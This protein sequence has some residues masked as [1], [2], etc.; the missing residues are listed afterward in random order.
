M[1][2]ASISQGRS[3]L[4]S[5]P[6]GSGKTLAAFLWAIDR[7]TFG[8]EPAPVVV[9]AARGKKR[10][11][12][13]AAMAPTSACR[14]LYVSPLKALAVDVERN[15]RA[16]IAGI[17]QTASAEGLR[18]RNVRVGVRTGDTSTKE[19]ELLKRSPPDILVTTPESLYL[20][21]T[22][23]AR[24][25]LATIDTVIVDEIHQLAGEKRGAHFFLSLERLEALR[26]ASRPDAPKLLRIGL[27]ATQK[28][29]EVTARLLAGH[30]ARGPREV[31]IAEAP[32]EKVFRVTVT[33]PEGAFDGQAAEGEERRPESSAWPKL[34][35]RLLEAI[36]AKRST[37]IFVNSRR[38]AERLAAALNDLAA[39]LAGENPETYPPLALAHHGSLARAAREEI[40]EKLKRGELRA[41]VATSSL[42]LGID[43]GAVDQVV[44]VESP[45]SIAAGIQRIGRAGHQVGAV[46]EGL[47]LPKHKADL[48]AATAAKRAIETGD[49]EP[50][51]VPKNPLDVLAQQVVA[52]VATGI[53]IEDAEEPPPIPADTVFALVRGTE[54]FATLPR[55]AFDGVL[56][57]LS[58]RYPSTDFS[59]LR[60]RLSWDRRTGLLT[61]RPFARRL[62]VLNAGTIPERG[63]Y[64]V[65]L[66]GSADP[67]KKRSLRVGELDEEM[68][69]ELREGDTFFLGASAWKVVDITRDQVIVNPA[70]GARGRPPFWHG[71]RLGR[72]KSFGARIGEL[73][74]AI[75]SREEAEARTYLEKDVGLDPSSAELLA[76]YVHE[77]MATLGDSPSDKTLVIERFQDEL[78]DHR[79][80]ILSPFGAR[81][82]APWAVAIRATLSGFRDGD[83]EAVYSDDGITLR[84]PE[85]DGPPPLEALALDP[86]TVNEIVTAE[87]GH[88]ALFAARFREAAGRA[89]LLPKRTPGKRTP[90]WALR[91]KSSDLLAVASRYPDFPLML[92]VHR[93]CL[94]DAFDMTGLTELLE[95]I[96]ARK[97]R[98]R[99]V[100][101]KTPSAFSKSLLFSFVANFLYDGDAPLAERR[102]QALLVDPEELRALLGEAELRKL[103]DPDIARALEDE[104]L[105]LKYPLTT[106]DGLHDLLLL[107]GDLSL[108]EVTARFE[109]PDGAGAAERAIA[110]LVEERRIAKVRIARETRLVA[111]EDAARYRDALGVVLPP[112][113]PQA[114]LGPT[115]DAK[116]GIF[117]RYARTHAPFS[118]G[119]LAARYALSV[120]SVEETLDA[121]VLEGRLA[122]GAFLAVPDGTREYA[123]RE[124]LRALRRRNVFALRKEIEPVTAAAYARFALGWHGVSPLEEPD[125]HEREPREKKAPKRA[126]ADRLLE[127]IARLEGYPLPFTSLERDILPARVPGFRPWDLDALMAQGEIVW[128]GVEALGPSDGRIAL[129]LPE[130]DSL[131]ARAPE[132]QVREA[133]SP[134]AHRVLEH[135]E[136]RG[137]SFFQEITR[138]LGGFPNDLAEALHELVW[139]GFVTNDTLEPL[140]SAFASAES[141]KKSSRARPRPGHARS[142]R[143]ALLPGTEGR[144]SARRDHDLGVRG[145]RA[146]TE[147]ERR[148]ALTKRVLERHGVLLREAVLH[149]GIAGG[150]SALYDVLAALEDRGLARRGYFVEGRGTAQFAVPGADDRLRASRESTGDA[151]Y[152]LAAVDPAN[153]YGS[154]IGWPETRDSARPS[155]SAGAHVALVDGALAAWI[156]KSFDVAV[157][158]PGSYAQDARLAA[159][160]C[161]KAL[162]RVVASSAGPRGIGLR[163]VDGVPANEHPERAA[164]ER[165]GFALRRDLLSIVRKAPRD[166]GARHPA[167]VSAQLPEDP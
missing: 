99:V 25:G 62:A 24:R 68:V 88:T 78:G 42:E 1:A 92:E 115:V 105:R 144:F 7:L 165:H 116:K 54:T 119:V 85:G 26:A 156:S 152:W 91:K 135:L 40:E 154:A 138:S 12:K 160:A 36:Y 93:E 44:Q 108:A 120:S 103:L 60:P 3:T 84:V 121:L 122:T 47:V 100:D 146:P 153:P 65:F 81:V 133:L 142:A 75:A 143:R 33:V 129:Y 28:P 118:S 86:D 158:F 74:R 63:L 87:V 83:I 72:A 145:E 70:D 30:D 112:G 14:V 102:A 114:L 56:D 107:L 140:R 157:T 117:S 161:A 59:E 27:S 38:L 34:H 155:R 150:F 35:E 29:L 13:S 149:E 94:Q 23:S 45:P 139:A 49:I 137:A 52:I 104:L 32:R 96:R 166:E 79:V 147:T 125:E 126:D 109:E 164:F 66:E 8:E 41:I 151:L 67:E 57:M 71:D 141:D 80:C 97:V 17:A 136:T 167:W 128:R 106:R 127:A 9:P 130:G 55:S 22:G 69:F 98:V 15:L 131:I 132:A 162:A 6:T 64:G 90:L 95:E 10:A 46:S 43:M 39:E 123:D 159:E 163:T 82:H 18:G 19:R 37:M 101:T 76:G 53:S 2:W 111:A 51:R 48:L 134:L 148:T 4:L 20:M 124:V 61:A 89:L 50:T 16:P 113:L 73:S 5:A 110:E 58:G 11:A 77:G 31:V 21:L